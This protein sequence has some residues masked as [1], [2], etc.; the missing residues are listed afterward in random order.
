MKSRSLI[1]ILVTLLFIIV[2]VILVIS[3]NRDKDKIEEPVPLARNGVAVIMTGAAA[4]IPQ[5]AALLEELD[6]RG[7]LQDVVFIS[8]VSSGALN[9]VVLNGILS[10]KFTWNEYHRIL[11]HL[12]NSDIFTQ[13]ENKL[14][15]N[16]SPARELFT[17]IFEN[18]LGYHSIGDLPYPTEI[19]FTHLNPFDLKKTVYRMCNRKINPETD[20]TLSLVD[21]VMASSAF[22]VVFPAIRIS[23]VSTIP[24][25]EYI[26]GGIG[27]DH[28]PYHALLEFEK[29]RG[30]GV[31]K[32]Y[33]ISR[34]SDS[35]P[36]ISKELSGLG[37]ND[38]G[39][40]DKLNI[41]LDAILSKGIM[42][43]LEEYTASAPELV[44][45]TYVWIPQYSA[46]FLL[47]N[48]DDL[49]EQYLLTTHWA[50][51]NKPVPLQ[52]FLLTHQN[53]G[54]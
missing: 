5:E 26:D 47:F 33:I 27:E 8:G 18:K 3:L 52:D 15:L 50:R 21:I 11:N 20:T 38:R 45:L 40:F 25:V 42:K 16:T 23:N 37:I 2:T 7:L 1:R 6:R 30:V 31:E 13:E 22:P 4:R 51:K 28:V 34:K 19:S 14:P 39:I 53:N 43:R 48:F 54:N 29:Y 17:D 49:K 36:E 12:K 44:P 24:D 9:A 32:V 10:G 46:N 41:S 35:K